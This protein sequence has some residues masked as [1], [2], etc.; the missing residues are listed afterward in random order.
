MSSKVLKSSRFIAPLCIVL[1]LVAVMAFMAQP[2]LYPDNSNV[3]G[4]ICATTLPATNIG[5]NSATLNGANRCMSLGVSSNKVFA[6]GCGTCGNFEWGPSHV[7]QG[8]VYPYQTPSQQIEGTNTF[9]AVITNLSPFT[10]YYYRVA[11]FGCVC[12]TNNNAVF[13][14]SV[15]YGAEVSFTTLGNAAAI[16]PSTSSDVSPTVG[17]P[18]NVF[19]QFNHSTLVTQ[20]NQPVT[21]TANV[22]NNGDVE[23]GFTVNLK[24]D[25]YIEQTKMGVIPG[26]EAET[27]E[28]T[29]V[30]DMPGTYELDID[31]N[32]ATLT[33]LAA[34]QSS[35]FTQSQIIFIAGIGLA[36]LLIAFVAVMIMR[37]RA[38]Q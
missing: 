5:T 34:E 33:V 21:V 31:G 16:N 36:I 23:G 1:V 4:M 37:R 30:K 3:S 14:S 24:V 8:G 18:A 35:A 25:G 12:Q 19:T 28:F 29:I 9:S 20:V 7:G 27:V 10:T 2:G 11:L 22:I 6:D 13:A 15:D 17:V 32:T 38:T 26:H